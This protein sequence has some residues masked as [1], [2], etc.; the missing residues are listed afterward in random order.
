MIGQV[1]LDRV[2]MVRQIIGEY[3]AEL[4]RERSHLEAYKIELAKLEYPGEDAALLGEGQEAKQCNLE[5]HKLQNRIEFTEEE[6]DRMEQLL[7]VFRR[8]LGELQ[9]GE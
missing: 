1:A 7:A 9:R 4:A 2:V 8:K 6:I 5:V 3:E